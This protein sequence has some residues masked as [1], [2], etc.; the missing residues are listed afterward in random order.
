VGA[1]SVVVAGFAEDSLVGQPTTSTGLVRLYD[2]DGGVQG[3]LQ[4]GNNGAVA[5]GVA[6]DVTGGY[7]VGNNGGNAFGQALGDMDGFVTKITLPAPTSLPFSIT[8]L[9]GISTT[10]DGTRRTLCRTWKH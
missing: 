10:T 9:T 2:F 7:I 4:F 3:T 5:N 6:A 8:N 1:A